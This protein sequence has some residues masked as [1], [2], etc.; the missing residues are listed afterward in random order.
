MFF[1]DTV[2]SKIVEICI[3]KDTSRWFVCHS[4]SL[5]RRICGEA[6]LF[7]LKFELIDVT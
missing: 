7:Y 4:Y 1:R 6:C 3:T 2:A 5:E